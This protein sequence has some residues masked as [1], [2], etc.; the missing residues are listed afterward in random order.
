MHDVKLIFT[1]RTTQYESYIGRL[2]IV[3]LADSGRF[4]PALLGLS[5]AA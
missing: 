2:G 3:N 1:R 4:F 5:G